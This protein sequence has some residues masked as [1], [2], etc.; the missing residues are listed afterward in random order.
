MK[1]DDLAILVYSCWR[2]SDMW[3]IFLRMFQKYW[4]DCP[5]QLILLT[6]RIDQD[7]QKVRCR[8]DDIVVLDGTWYEMVMAG[9]RK[10]DTEYVMLWMDDYLLCDKVKN[11]DI[12]YFLSAAKKYQ[13]ANIRLNEP[14][15][16][17]SKNVRKNHSF[18]VCKPGTAYSLSTQ[19]GIWD[20]V[21]L[22][23]NINVKWTAWDFER[24]GSIE[25]RDFQHPLLVSCNYCFPYE[26]VVRRGKWMDNGVRICDRNNIRIDFNRRKKM[27]DF[28]M[29]WIYFKGGILKISPTVIVKIQNFVGR[30][31]QV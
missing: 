6:D 10:A 17:I 9:I 22:K 26:E 14:R 20:A 19:I 30:M 18:K 16:S 31:H 12:K 23:E 3:D 11:S 4:S 28:E 5:Y 2:N 15:H 1:K 7:C 21:W 25:I 27:N 8:F 29:A 13:A 24:I